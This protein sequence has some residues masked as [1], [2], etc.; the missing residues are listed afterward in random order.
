MGSNRLI[1]KD[2]ADGTVLG[3]AVVGGRMEPYLTAVTTTGLKGIAVTGNQNGAVTVTPPT[4]SVNLTIP[5]NAQAGLLIGFTLDPNVSFAQVNIMN[6]SDYQQSVVVRS[7]NPIM[8]G[9]ADGSG[10]YMF[11]VPGILPT[12]MWFV[13]MAST[14]TRGMV[15]YR[16]AGSGVGM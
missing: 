7:V 3:L 9:K 8:G 10:G 13:S 4:G 1:L 15:S 2:I 12:S 16:S 14:A 5:A 6:F 11:T